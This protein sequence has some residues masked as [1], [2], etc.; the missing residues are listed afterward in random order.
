MASLLRLILILLNLISIPIYL[1]FIISEGFL[2]QVAGAITIL[3]LL[4]LLLFTGN[5]V[6]KKSFNQHKKS[7]EP[8]V[9]GEVELPVPVTKEEID[10]PDKNQNITRSRRR[11][12]IDNLPSIQIENN[13]QEISHIEYQADSK[14]DIDV[15]GLAKV[16]VATSDPDSQHELEVEQLISVKRD[17]RDKVKDRLTRERRM[18]LAKNIA[19]KVA[20]WADSEDGEDFTHILNNN[21]EIKILS[22]PEEYNPNIPQGISFVRVDSNRI[23]KIRVSLIVN[24]NTLTKVQD[25]DD[26]TD[27]DSYNTENSIPPPIGFVDSPNSDIES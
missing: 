20:Q 16:Y 9:V 12:E 17:M 6:T 8:I 25:Y 3:L 14:S 19:K 4:S 24:H 11:K 21:S 10:N 5:R 26:F 22:E 7:T 23:I 15:E 2:F 1:I 13:S 18:I 27:T